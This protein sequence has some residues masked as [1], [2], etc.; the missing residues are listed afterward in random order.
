MSRE[1]RRRYILGKISGRQI[2]VTSCEPDIIPVN[3]YEGNVTF[4]N[5]SAG[6]VTDN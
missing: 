6:E 2:I 4:K 1:E 3:Y 5:V